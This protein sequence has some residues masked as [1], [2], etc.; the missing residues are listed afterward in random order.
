MD[1][2]SGDTGMAQILVGEGGLPLV[3]FLVWL[4][5][6]ETAVPGLGMNENPKRR[7]NG[8]VQKRDRKLIHPRRAAEFFEAFATFVPGLGIEDADVAVLIDRQAGADLAPE[9]DVLR[10]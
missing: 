2:Q 4:H 8:A 9:E 7:Q 10:G 1:T 5:A 6:K 3:G